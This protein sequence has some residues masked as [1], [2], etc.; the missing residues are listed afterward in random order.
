MDAL[1]ESSKYPEASWR[2]LALTQPTL[3]A[4][5]RINTFWFRPFNAGCYRLGIIVDE[6]EEEY[7]HTKGARNCVTRRDLHI[8]KR[9]DIA[10]DLDES[11]ASSALM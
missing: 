2:Q 10:K 11:W 8:W 1:P 4:G 5:F 6:L 7:S 9:L 3:D